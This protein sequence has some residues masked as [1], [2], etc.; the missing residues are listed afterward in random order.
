MKEKAYAGDIQCRLYGMADPGPC[1]FGAVLFNRSWTWT[2][3]CLLFLLPRQGTKENKNK[4]KV[5]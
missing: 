2:K 5:S 4:N 3:N 1:I